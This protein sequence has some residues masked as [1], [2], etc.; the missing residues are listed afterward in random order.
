MSNKITQFFKKLSLS[1]LPR[2]SSE[3]EILASQDSAL[4][5][6]ATLEA[7]NQNSPIFTSFLHSCT[8]E[9]DPALP[10]SFN[11]S[12]KPIRPAIKT[13]PKNNEGNKF[14]DKWYSDHTWLEYSKSKNAAF[15]FVC[16]H[17]GENSGYVDKIYT[18]DGF[19][20]FRKGPRRFKEHASSKEHLTASHKYLQRMAA[21]D[22]VAS[23]VNSHHKKQITENRKGVMMNVKVLRIGETSLNSSNSSASTI[24]PSFHRVDEPSIIKVMESRM[25]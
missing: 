24:P 17:F 9:I 15:C 16:R 6:A 5:S 10:V 13:Y 8:I 25:K 1:Q 14:N 23:N 22:S 12:L 19:T 20:T 18:K 21:S 3:N 4:S 7:E 11:S 2:V